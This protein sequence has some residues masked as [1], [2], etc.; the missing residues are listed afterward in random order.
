ML[1]D[2]MDKNKYHLVSNWKM[3]SKVSW[4]YVQGIIALFQVE[5]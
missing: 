3:L 1:V 2:A 4:S 5:R